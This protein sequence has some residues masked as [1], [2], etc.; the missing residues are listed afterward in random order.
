MIYESKIKDIQYLC[1]TNIHPIVITYNYHPFRILY[2]NKSWEYLCG[3]S[4]QEI[5][6]KSI[7]ILKH[8]DISKNISINKRKNKNLFLHVFEIYDIPYLN[9]SIGTTI[10][11]KNL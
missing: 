1:S 11:Y 7:F 4:F 2:V 9:I 8:K 10:F 5:V 6:G 3:Y